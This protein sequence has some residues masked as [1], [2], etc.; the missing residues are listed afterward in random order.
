MYEIYNF[1]DFVMELYINWKILSIIRNIPNWKHEN[2]R[3]K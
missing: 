2:K 3:L 1:L